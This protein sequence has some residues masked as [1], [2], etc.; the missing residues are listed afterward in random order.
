MLKS[1]NPKISILVTAYNAE[2]LIEKTI[3][4]CMNQS[5]SEIE[6][7]AVSDG[8]VDHTSKI[9][10]EM[11]KKDNRITVID[12]ENRGHS[13]ALNIALDRASGEYIAFVEGGDY[14]CE[15]F[16]Y[17]LYHEAKEHNLDVCTSNCYY[18]VQDILSPSVI[19]T[20]FTSKHTVMSAEQIYNTAAHGVVGVCLGIYKRSFL[21]SNQ[22]R[23]DE[24]FCAYA[25]VLFKAE[26]YLCVERM[27]VIA[28]CL[29]YTKKSSLLPTENASNYHIM[30]DIA[31]EV[32]KLLSEGRGKKERSNAIRSYIISYLFFYYEKVQQNADLLRTAEAISLFVSNHFPEGL[33]FIGSKACKDMLS[34]LKISANIQALEAST[35][36][37]LEEFSSYEKIRNYPYTQLLSVC[38]LKIALY[39]RDIFPSSTLLLARDFQ[40]FILNGLIDPDAKKFEIEN[41]T[42][43]LL[44]QINCADIMCLKPKN[45]L[46]INL[47][48]YLYRHGDKS[49]FAPIENL[50]ANNPHLLD[51]AMEHLRSTQYLKTFPFESTAFKK[52]SF[53]RMASELSKRKF[54]NFIKGKSIAI[55]GNSPVELGKGKGKSIDS[56]DIV[57]R[58]NNFTTNVD[59][60]ADYGEKTDVWAM[61]PA[62]SNLN[63]R[64]NAYQCSYVM[65]AH[66][67][68]HL[69]LEHAEHMYN[70]MILGNNFLLLDHY[71]ISMSTNIGRP[72]LGLSVVYFL[73]DYLKEI[74]G[75]GLFGFSMLDAK[76]KKRHY[77]TG[78]PIPSKK[79]MTHDWPK[80]W[81]I[82]NQYLAHIRDEGKLLS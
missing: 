63:Y 2:Q 10:H 38:Y 31:A 16:C 75:I 60:V 64:T 57:I 3:E 52:M 56:Y 23:F 54:L 55:V 9:M 19:Y 41:T 27:Q 32:L 76:K 24:N 48:A 45:A 44:S 5:L 36:P 35:L 81:E 66:P 6:I 39:R 26:I 11:A 42:R 40:H 47:F 67:R 79:L 14:I 65:V 12:K 58:F 30:L 53:V 4:S 49:A 13:S 34:A 28:T 50:I 17:I 33:S 43:L 8:S 80:E 25:D 29:Y 59:T 15:D 51:F 72:S 69:M 78:D 77:F 61:T 1:S 73:L 62:L 7:I 20:Y 22:L 71:Q 46:F 68:Q 82:Y 74:K 70:Q 37:R 21:N 18:E